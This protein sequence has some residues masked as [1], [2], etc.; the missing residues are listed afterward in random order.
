MDR[1]SF[2]GF[3]GV[4]AAVSVVGCSG[5]STEDSDPSSSGENSPTK[6]TTPTATEKDLPRPYTK[7]PAHVLWAYW[8]QEAPSD[9]EPHP[10]D[11]PPVSDHDVVHTVF[12]D[13]LEQGVQEALDD[14]GRGND[15]FWE[16]S[17]STLYEIEYAFDD[18]E[19]NGER[20][21]YFK[22]DGEVVALKF[23]VPD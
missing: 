21:Q 20:P 12:D 18:I 7:G 23:D 6:P 3:C 1:R 4:A 11:E 19:G 10:S 14:T 8:V 5:R 22:H 15:V 16:V 13:A 17:E 9:I 2:L